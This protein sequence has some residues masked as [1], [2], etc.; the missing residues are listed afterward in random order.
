[1]IEIGHR[2]LYRML[3]L[4]ERF[5]AEKVEFWLG[6]QCLR[7]SFPKHRNES[8][9]VGNPMQHKMEHQ[10]K[11]LERHVKRGIEPKRHNADESVHEQ[12]FG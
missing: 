2:P 5:A 8:R 4:A 3:R 12:V 9:D 1:M 7:P 11:L 10:Q 6:W